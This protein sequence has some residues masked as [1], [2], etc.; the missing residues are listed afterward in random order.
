MCTSCNKSF[1]LSTSL[2]KHVK[3]IHEKLKQYKCKY[4]DKLYGYSTHLSVHIKTHEDGKIKRYSCH[5]CL[6][7]FG[8]NQAMNLHIR[9]IH[10]N[11]KDHKCNICNGSFHKECDLKKHMGTVHGKIKLVYGCSE[12]NQMFGQKQSLRMH[13][14][15]FH[16]NIKV[17]CDFCDLSFTNDG[18]NPHIKRVHEKIKDKK[19]HLCDTVAYSDGRSL[20]RHLQTVH[21]YVLEDP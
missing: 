1:S 11:M 19:C 10:E 20:I 2:R 9:Y 16:K 15:N 8:T 18:L 21:K 7:T 4:C 5:I 13:I 14:E 6:K 17:K 3:A 12:C